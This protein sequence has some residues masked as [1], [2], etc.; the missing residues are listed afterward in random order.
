MEESTLREA[1]VGTVAEE[2]T[3]PSIR[4]RKTRRYGRT[5]KL[6]RKQRGRGRA[7]EH[8]RAKG[9]IRLLESEMS[10]RPRAHDSHFSRVMDPDSSASEECAD[11]GDP[12]GAGGIDTFC[13][14]RKVDLK[15]SKASWYMNADGEI[16]RR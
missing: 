10:R 3:I 16:G 6:P 9:E 12:D 13:N 4:L 5:P 2:A 11:H 14:T 8:L 1:R 15:A 7:T